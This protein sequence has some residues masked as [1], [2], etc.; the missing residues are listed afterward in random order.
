[1][2]DSIQANELDPKSFK[3]CDA[4]VYRIIQI[5]NLEDEKF[6][7]GGAKLPLRNNDTMLIFGVQCGKEKLDL[8]HGGKGPSDFMQRRCANVSRISLKVIKDL[9]IEAICGR[10]ERDEEDVAKLVCLYICAKLFFATTG[11]CGEVVGK[12]F[13][14]TLLILGDARDPL[15]VT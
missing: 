1:M 15:L 4:T 2:I 14:N 8:A 10:T 5:Y 12:W 6:H 3:K 7:I 11:E 13:G 9:L